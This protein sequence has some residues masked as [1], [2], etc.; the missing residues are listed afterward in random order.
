[1]IDT[2]REIAGWASVA[3]LVLSMS[4]RLLWEWW[5]GEP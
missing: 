1:V 5:Q 4:A 2:L 3:A